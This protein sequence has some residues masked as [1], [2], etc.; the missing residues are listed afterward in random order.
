MENEETDP[1][2]E[3]EEKDDDDDDDSDT[4]NPFQPDVHSTPGPS[5]EDIPMTTMNREKE[6]GPGIAETSFIEGSTHSRVLE[7]DKKAWESLT[8]EF[9]DANAIELEAAYSKTGKLQV[10]MFGQGKKAYPLFTKDK[11]TGEQRLNPILPK[12]I[13][14]ALG[15]E[16]EILIA[17]K[18]KEIE[19]LQESI[20]EDQEIANNENEEPAVRE[21]AREKIAEKLEQ[22]DAIENERDELE[23]RL[24]LREKVK[25]IFK[26][27]GF[28]VTAVFLAVG[29]VIGVIVNSLTKGLKSVATGVG[30]GLKELGKK[31]AGI[32]PGLI[33]A[34]VSFIFK[35][36]GSVISFLGK[37]CLAPYS[38]CCGVHG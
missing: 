34:I 29:T 7:L 3:N 4:T 2:L 23:E 31:I 30:N 16:R 18:E 25:N 22:I 24:S 14:S 1:L 36:A 6:K 13:K 26:K 28:T 33:G 20:R 32:L 35:T 9:P 11:N 19:E 21:R 8:R 37:K 27:Y 38:W 10:K 15:P 5:N 17:Q 12:E